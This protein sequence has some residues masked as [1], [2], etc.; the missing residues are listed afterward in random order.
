MLRDTSGQDRVIVKHRSPLQRFGLPAI[1]A[2]VV[3]AAGLFG[4]NKMNKLFASDMSVDTERLRFAQVVRGDLMRDIAVQGR[5]VA[6]NS[7]TLYANSGGIVTLYIKAGDRVEAGQTLAMV[8]S[9]ELKNRLAQELATLEQLKLEVG[10]QSIQI[11]SARLNNQQAIEVAEVNLD[12]ASVE[13]Q[14]AE[15][16]VTDSLISQ[17]EY[18]EKVAAFKRASLVHKHAK[19]NYSIQEENMSLELQGMQSQLARQQHVVD[20]LHRQIAQL[21]LASPTDGVIGSVYVRQKDNVAANSA[22]ITVVDLSVLEI[23]AAIPENFADDLGVGLQA[24]ISVNGTELQGELVAISP[25]VA[26]GQVE[27]R[28]RFTQASEQ[29]LR[30]NQK[31]SARILI[32]AKSDVLKLKRGEFLESGGGRFAYRV[33]GDNAHRQQ[34]VFGSRSITEVEVLSGLA[35]GDTVIIS[36]TAQFREQSQLYLNN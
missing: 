2:F 19:Q 16:S 29:Q 21:T 22:L 6:A 34:V 20:E 26:D 28:I 30:Q 23:E 9:P 33:S 36:N 18:E 10:R 13:K 3:L 5:V 7:P 8:D 32:E 27:G 12:S 14:R 35:E 17:R 15:I 31:V 25:E 1:V 11:K 4:L 24:E